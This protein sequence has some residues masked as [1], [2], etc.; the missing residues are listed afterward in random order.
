MSQITFDELSV[1]F[2]GPQLIPDLELYNFIIN[3]VVKKNLVNSIRLGLDKFKEIP[4]V[5][6]VRRRT[7]ADLYWAAKYF[8]WP[9]CPTGVGKPIEVNLINEATHRP[10][11]DVFIKK[12]DTKSIADQD[13]VYKERFIL[14]PRGSFKSSI[15]VIDS[16]QWILNFPDIRILY[17]TATDKLAA[18]FVD[19]TRGHFVIREDPSPM[20]LFFPEFCVDEKKL[21]GETF[22]CPIWLANQVTRKESTIMAASIISTVSGL[23]FEIIKPDDMV[24]NINSQTPEGCAK[25]SKNWDI[26]KNMLV[27]YGYVVMLGTRY[28]EEDRYG[29]EIE[30]N[31]GDIEIIKGLDSASDPRPWELFKNPVTGKIILIGKGWEVKP[32][33]RKKLLAN[34]IKEDDLKKEDWYILFPELLSYET[35]RRKQKENEAVFEGQINQNPRP[36]RNITFDKPLLQLHTIP[37]NKVPATAPAII[38]WDFAFSQKKK[39][40]YSTCAVSVYNAK[41]QLYVIDLVRQRFSPTGLAK[42]VVDQAERYRPAVLAIED[43]AGS[44]LLE[45]TIMAEAEN[46]KKQWLLDVCRRIE[47]FVPDQQE[48]AKRIRMAALHPLLMSDRLWFVSHLPYLDVLYNEFER[49]LISH[50]HDDIPD[51]I[52]QQVRWLPKIEIMITKRELPAWS[53]EDAAWNLI[54]EEHCDAFGRPGFSD[55]GSH[56]INPTEQP[57][58][59]LKPITPCDGL[60]PLLGAGL[61]G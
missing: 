18:G 38:T 41:S 31:V 51:V 42:S 9:S 50:H 44:R 25:V 20:N 12:D 53:R 48:D 55:A 59:G 4:V 30:K 2:H 7:K 27:T 17:L 11:C 34:E 28:A 49:C 6:E 8:C 57:D 52:A 22:N 5:K 24:D 29:E 45:P 33:P 43:C 19:E 13:P 14:Y 21:V 26:D 61:V 39:R 40:D 37:F 58:T 47:W 15:D 10:L 36:R 23:H 32:E 56:V 46:R 60:P 35:L 54:Y 3:P 1:Q 16:V